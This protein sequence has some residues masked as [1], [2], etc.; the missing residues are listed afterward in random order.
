MTAQTHPNRILVS[1]HGIGNVWLNP[2]THHHSFHA[3]TSFAEGDIMANFTARTTQ[4]YPT[5]L[6]I[7]KGAN[8]HITFEPSYLELINHSCDPNV[9]FDTDAMEMICIRSIKPDDEICFFYPSTEW[10]MDRPFECNCGSDKCLKVIEG[11]FAIDPQI[12]SKY[13]LTNYISQQVKLNN[14]S[15]SI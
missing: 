7:Q 15:N 9:F 1:Q 12:L 2:Q 11:A 6:T 3:A 4:A 5:Y 14:K 13:R 8:V 10:Q